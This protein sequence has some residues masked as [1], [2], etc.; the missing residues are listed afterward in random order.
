MQRHDSEDLATFARLSGEV[1]AAYE[2]SDSDPWEASPFLWI[3][4]TR[5]SSRRGAIGAA[6]VRAW[7]R[8][9]GSEVE[10]ALNSGHDLRIDG[11]K[12]EVK[13]SLL[14]ESGVFKFQQIR[15]QDYETAVL[16]GI[17]PQKVSMWAV[18]KSELWSDRVPFQ[19]GGRRGR[20]TKWL[21]FRPGAAPDWLSAYGP[22]LVL[23][24]AALEEARR[25]SR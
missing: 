23:A 16:L 19:H 12:V 4:Q 3:H 2:S 7:A 25:G 22:T 10:A 21:S 9:C 13:T 20:D 1:Q 18:P 14:W 15:D 8:D 17:E 5:S 24:S 11:L 6:L